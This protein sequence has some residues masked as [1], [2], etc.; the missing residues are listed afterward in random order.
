MSI[1]KKIVFSI[2]PIVLFGYVFLNLFFYW[3]VSMQVYNTIWVI[4]TVLVLLYYILMYSL[5]WSEVKPKS[6]KRMHLILVILFAPY[7][8]Y[9][10]WFICSKKNNNPPGAPACL[11]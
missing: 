7:G 8:L 2:I 1:L 5:I 9:Y 4:A 11:S 10:I 3:D 6:E